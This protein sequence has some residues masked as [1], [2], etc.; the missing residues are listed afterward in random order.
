MNKKVADTMA[1]LEQYK[2]KHIQERKQ[3]EETSEK[4]I[5]ENESMREQILTLQRDLKSRTQESKLS[6]DLADKLTKELKQK[7]EEKVKIMDTLKDIQMQ[8]QKHI[9]DE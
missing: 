3:F 6:S 9:N 8:M 5:L 7:Q 2:L 4:A 1:E